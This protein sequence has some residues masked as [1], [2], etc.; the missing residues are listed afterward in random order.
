MIAG[1]ATALAVQASDTAIN[2]WG[3]HR[4]SNHARMV[5]AAAAA[6]GVVY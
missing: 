3:S 5:Y 2:M 1:L 6:A 4:I